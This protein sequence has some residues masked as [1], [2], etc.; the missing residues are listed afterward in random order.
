MES[1]F[2]KQCKVCGTK[3]NVCFHY[4][5]RTCR[6]CGAFFRRYLEN[7]TK[8]KYKC[9]C[10]SKQL[11]NEN[12]DGKSETNLPKCRKCRLEKCLSVGMKRLNV[13]YLRQDLCHD[14]M[15]EGRKEINLSNPQI[16]DISN[17]D[18]QQINSILPI[19]EAQK[20]IMHAF[21]DLDDI[22]LKGPILFEEIISSNFNI[23]RL[24]GTFSPN[25]SPIP[26]DEF[27]SWESSFKDKGI[28]NKSWHKYFLVDRLLCVGIAKS[29]PVFDKLTL[30]DQ[31]IEAIYILYLANFSL[32]L[33]EKKMKI[34]LPWVF[35]QVDSESFYP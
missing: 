31:V 28:I 2:I 11:S 22:F 35:Y 16:V 25:P 18:R 3:E 17:T 9:K 32:S 8:R 30:S 34:I 21:N 19:I 14:E 20:R 26:F 29:L 10:L 13:V 24:T 27:K 12:K 23:F 15:K 5:V 4:G 7:E 6:S 1:N 33:V